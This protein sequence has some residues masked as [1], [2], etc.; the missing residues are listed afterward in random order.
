MSGDTISW[1]VRG[2]VSAPHLKLQ[3]RWCSLATL[4]VLNGLC[5]PLRRVVGQATYIAAGNATAAADFMTALV[6]SFSEQ[7]AMYNLSTELITVNATSA[8]TTPTA[9]GTNRLL[10]VVSAS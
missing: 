1:H 4:G 5:T 3:S 9:G 8:P 7:Y 2:S 6:Q 10:F